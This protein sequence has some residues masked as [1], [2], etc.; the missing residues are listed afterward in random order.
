MAP[1]VGGVIWIPC[2]VKPGP[3]SNERLVRVQ[4][5]SGEWLGFVSVGSL[6]DPLTEGRTFVR[7][8]IAAI[9]DDRFE[10]Y[11]AGHAVTSNLFAGSVARV[12]SL[13]SIEAGHSPV[14][15]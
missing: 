13:G 14:Y 7:G 1:K 5:D 4:S 11:L 2:E 12:T 9:Q 6:Q 15:Q 3:F 8:T 10:V